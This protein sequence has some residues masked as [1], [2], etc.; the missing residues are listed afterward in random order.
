MPFNPLSCSQ[1]PINKHTQSKTEYHPA[2][3]SPYSFSKMKD[4]Q[5]PNTKNLE[6]TSKKPGLS[7][8][9]GGQGSMRNLFTQ[10]NRNLHKNPSS[11]NLKPQHKANQ[12]SL[13]PQN[14]FKLSN[15]PKHRRNQTK[16]E[17]VGQSKTIDI[18]Q[19]N[20]NKLKSTG[21]NKARII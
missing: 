7:R 19:Q 21:S 1:T 14:S 20:V 16:Y 8:E 10:S 4:F 9:Y 15:M 12:P 5:T 13:Q 2:K 17:G 6:S 11:K 3:P 18:S